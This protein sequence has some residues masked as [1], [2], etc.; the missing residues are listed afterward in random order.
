[1]YMYHIIHMLL[2][3]SLVMCEGCNLWSWE[4]VLVRGCPSP[5]KRGEV[6]KCST[7][8]IVH[9]QLD[10]Q[11]LTITNRELREREGERERE[12]T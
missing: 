6:I 9:Y 4:K 11:G 10:I 12:D 7:L 8:R 2:T 5:E 1:M 3:F